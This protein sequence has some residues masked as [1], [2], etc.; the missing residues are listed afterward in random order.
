MRALSA[1]DRI[2]DPPARTVSFGP[3]WIFERP[4][5]AEAQGVDLV[6][7]L[8]GEPEPEVLRQAVATVVRRNAGSGWPSLEVGAAATAEPAIALTV[9]SLAGS[10][11]RVFSRRMPVACAAPTTVGAER[12]GP[13]VHVQ[14]LEVGPSDFGLLLALDAL[15]D[16]DECLRIAG[17]LA[18]AYHAIRARE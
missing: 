16:E 15:V 18:D 8:A 9:A 11:G 14:L 2:P 1:V 17:D 4:E 13:V 3:A 12:P 6:M 7:S 10:H 5:P